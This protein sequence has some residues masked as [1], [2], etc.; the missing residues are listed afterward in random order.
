MRRLLTILIIGT[1]ATQMLAQKIDR[2]PNDPQQIIHLKTA[3][4]HL[5]VIELREPVL[6]VAAG[7]QSFKVEWRE[8]KVFL[9]PT[10][11]D[12]S[13]NLFVWTSS[14]RLNYELEPAGSVV[15]MDFAVDQAPP[16]EPKPVS[17]RPQ[18]PS[19]TEVLLSGHPIRLESAKPST[20]SVEVTI[21]DL[22]EREG[23]LLVRYAVRN[24][25]A[26]TY[27]VTTPRVYALPGVRYPQS[28]YGLVDSQLGDRE[29]SR[30]DIKEQSPVSVIEGHVQSSH[31]QPGQQCLGLVA[32]RVPPSKEPMVLRFQ[33]AN[34]DREQVAAFLVR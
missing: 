15:E 7:S 20:R 19:P 29:A 4:N 14:H 33:F 10:E 32:L 8:N 12:A 16:V 34:D 18:E 21:R 17:V 23:R 27:E 9:Q 2:E 22:Y 1:A 26:H 11:P 13:T 24:N 6:Q 5:T 31:L 25:S 30:L 3:L 28:L